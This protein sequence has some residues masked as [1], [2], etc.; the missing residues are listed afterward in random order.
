MIVKTNYKC[1]CTQRNP[2]CDYAK[3]W[4]IEESWF[5][6]PL[7]YQ[8]LHFPNLARPALE[9]IQTP[10][11]SALGALIMVAKRPGRAIAYPH[12]SSAESKNAWNY[13]STH[14]YCTAWWVMKYGSDFYLYK[15]NNISYSKAN[16][17]PV[18]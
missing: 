10:T 9:S 8:T 17:S 6:S 3:D 4:S 5:D 18:C 13:T 16:F 1:T 14:S 7:G 15:T 12:P 11:L 2:Y